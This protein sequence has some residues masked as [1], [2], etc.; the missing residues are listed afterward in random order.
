MSHSHTQMLAQ[1]MLAG[2]R[3]PTSPI[4]GDYKGAASR[5]CKGCQPATHHKGVQVKAV[6]WK[7]SGER[8]RKE[9]AR[10]SQASRTCLWDASSAS[11]LHQ[12]SKVGHVRQVGSQV[13]AQGE[14][15][16]GQKLGPA[17]D[18]AASMLVQHILCCNSSIEG[19]MAGEYHGSSLDRCC[20]ALTLALTIH[21]DGASAT[22]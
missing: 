7:V 20:P 18:V 15:S 10:A 17:R 16:R 8:C 4:S 9:L 2:R 13:D 14:P 19:S 22:C 12:H 5:S 11:H 1:S 6:P 3:R 21:C